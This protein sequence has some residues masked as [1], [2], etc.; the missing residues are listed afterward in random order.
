MTV[1][2]PQPIER[3]TPELHDAL[4]RAVETLRGARHVLIVAHSSPDGDAIGST[5]GAALVVEAMGARV[6]RFNVDPVPDTFTFL[7]GAELVTAEA[8]SDPV[9]VT[10]MLDCSESHRVGEAFPPA[11]WGGL[12]VVLDHHQTVDRDFADVLVHDVS[13]AATAELVF[14]LALEAGIEISADIATCLFTALHTDTGSF[15]YGS[16]SAR[17]MLIGSHLLRTGIDAWNIASHIYE[18]QR[19]ERVRL[20]GAALQ[21][22]E[23]SPCGRLA[24]MVVTREMIDAAGAD[25]ADTDGFI[26]YARGIRGVE[27]AAQLTGD[28]ATGYRVSFR[29]RG[30][31]DVA[32]LAERFGGGGHRNAAGCTVHGALGD[33]R[34]RLTTALVNLLDGGEAA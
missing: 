32:S 19:P 24:T 26:N 13:A 31:V 5:L 11:A 16:T 6:T 7:P 2:S 30:R 28:D 14:R 21:S 23:R 1:S 8:P 4:E 33:V 17:A 15:R 25:S 20:L 29:S 3:G 10:V 9:D 27:V 18:D 12:V 22:I 34:A